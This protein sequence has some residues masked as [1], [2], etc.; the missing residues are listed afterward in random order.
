MV[1]SFSFGLVKTLMVYFLEYQLKM[2]GQSSLVLGLMLGSVV[3]SLYIWK[4]VS[5]YWDKGPAYALGMGIGAI[6]VAATFLLPHDQVNSIYIL[7]I[8][9]GFGF[10]TQWVFPWAIVADVVDYDRLKT[11]VQR[12]GM[13]YGVWGLTM[14]ISEALALVTTGWILTGFGYVANVEQTALARLGI[15]LFFG[16]VPAILILAALPL[17]IWFPLNRKRHAE[18][19]AKLNTIQSK[20]AD[21]LPIS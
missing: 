3:I 14:K 9:A 21:G 8:A 15:R 17:L 5:D 12:A 7:A 1:F 10:T 13:Y 16:P 11:G 20:V 2:P 6:A 19:M 18:I 4:K